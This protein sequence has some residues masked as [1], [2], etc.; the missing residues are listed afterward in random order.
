[1]EDLQKIIKE[2]KK[3]TGYTLTIVD[4]Q[5]C[6]STQ[7]REDGPL[8]S[9]DELYLCDMDIK[10][11]P[12]NLTVDGGL[13]LSG[14]GITSLPDN[15]TVTGNLYLDNCTGITS[16]PD[17]LTVGEDLDI[18][19][20]S[21]TSLPDNFAVGGSLYL[22][23]CTGITSLP[24]NLMVG[25]DLCLDNCTGL[26]SLPG[27]LIV[28]SSLYLRGC[29]GLTSLPDNL[30]VAGWLDISNTGLTSLPDNLTVG[31]G[32]ILGNTGIT[33][34]PENLIIG[35]DLE[36]GDYI[37]GLIPDNLT[38]GGRTYLRGIELGANRVN[39]TPVPTDARR[40]I[41]ARQDMCLT[42]ERSGRSYIKVDGIFSV[43]DSHYGNVWCVHQFGKGKQTYIVTDDDN[44]Y[45]HGDTIEEA[46]KDLVY[47]ICDRDI[48]EYENLTLDSELSYN[49][50][51]ECYRVITG[52]CS[53]GVRQFCENILTVKK[54]RYTVR[55]IIDLT[56]DEYGNEEFRD[57]FRHNI[58]KAGWRWSDCPILVSLV[59]FVTKMTEKCFHCGSKNDN[60][61]LG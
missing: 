3:E 50:A 11:L 27:N 19:G 51:I 60:H 56:E 1:M 12:D 8:F 61:R 38:L 26:T 55:E 2:F 33:F 37:V 47:K 41:A 45:A 58:Q 13:W 17:N 22:S 40:K 49:E 29:I 48:S 53:A 18:H 28:G 59:S 7:I 10:S 20:T 39:G 15:L 30:T 44:H 16:L 24:D 34:L 57:F 42:W 32:L 35:G 21:I 25:R 31:D 36:L 4:G 23:G 6:Y 5:L 46:R 43:V 52:A 14:T 9:V 54:D